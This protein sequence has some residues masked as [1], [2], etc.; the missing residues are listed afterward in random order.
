MFYPHTYN[1]ISKACLNFKDTPYYSIGMFPNDLYSKL[2]YHLTMF[3][4]NPVP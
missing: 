2:N 3:I 1:Y 4:E